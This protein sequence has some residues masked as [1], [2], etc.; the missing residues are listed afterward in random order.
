MSSRPSKRPRTDAFTWS[1]SDA[2]TPLDDDEAEAPEDAPI[3]L[4]LAS[5]RHTIGA[6][7]YD[8]TLRK[9]FVLEDAQDTD[10]HD[11]VTLLLEQIRP[12]V[13]LLSSRSDDELIDRIKAELDTL[14]A[15][16]ETIRH[17]I[18]IRPSR[19]FSETLGRVN[20]QSLRII[21]AMPGYDGEELG[22]RDEN[23]DD[24]E[25]EAMLKLAAFVNMQALA[26]LS[27]VACL[28]SCLARTST[29]GSDG[30][31]EVISIQSI[32]LYVIERPSLTCPATRSCASTR[33]RCSAS[34]KN[35]AHAAAHCR[36]SSIRLTPTR[37]RPRSKKACRCSAS[38]IARA[39]RSALFCFVSG[40]LV[41]LASSRSSLPA[42]MLS[43]VCCAATIVRMWP[44]CVDA[45]R[46][47]D[48]RLLLVTALG[49]EH[50][51]RHQSAQG[52]RAESRSLARCLQ[53]AWPRSLISH[54]QFL[55]AAIQIRDNIRHLIGAHDIAILDRLNACFDN[56]TWQYLGKL[57]AD[58]VR[59]RTYHADG[60]DRLGRE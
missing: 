52:R 26:M 12:E 51:S 16:T 30:L 45:S 39:P 27:S 14:N 31:E 41:R 25:S 19:E 47:P 24:H 22:G 3:T 9:L 37:R 44:L 29:V 2:A 32:A 56:R 1:D 38:S 49:Q 8:P 20:L 7:Y 18:E 35:L 46:A 13:V 48:R 33:M 23:S 58:F 5:N 17:R 34:P 54:T 40:S 42:K 50:P 15:T 4:A 36:S 11:L 21:E 53:C 55:H 59:A 28:L 10:K 43:T 6:A 57:I 60:A